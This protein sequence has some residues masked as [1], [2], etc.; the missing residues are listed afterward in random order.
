MPM[1]TMRDFGSFIFCVSKKTT[2]GITGLVHSVHMHDI[3][4]YVCVCHH[5]CS[6]D[7]SVTPIE[8]RNVM[9]PAALPPSLKIRGQKTGLFYC[10]E[11]LPVPC[12]GVHYT[13]TEMQGPIK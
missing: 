7:S 13:E 3:D 10:I 5:H 9:S 1:G 11:A 2:E 8:P 4:V 12:Q 6:R